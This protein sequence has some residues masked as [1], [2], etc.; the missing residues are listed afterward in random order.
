MSTPKTSFTD[1][2]VR[3]F[4]HSY[5]ENEQK[6]ED[7]FRLISLLQEWSGWEPR[8]WGPTIIG[9]GHYRNTYASGH[10]GEA[11]VLGFSPRK[12]AFSLYVHSDTER[13]HALLPRL[14]NYKMSKACLYI[15]RLS[16]IDPDILR[17]L[18]LESIEYI[19]THHVCS[20]HGS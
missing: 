14:G 16:D 5:V 15:K 19:R 6:R 7:S 17:E 1:Q 13:S 11:P 10:S 8:M 9:F 3:A 2:D 12:A 4:V 20:C 18:C